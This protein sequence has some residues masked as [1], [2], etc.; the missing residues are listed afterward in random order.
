MRTV[1]IL[2]TAFW[3]SLVTANAQL[4]DQ[5][6]R[7]MFFDTAGR[8]WLA[9]DAGIYSTADG[10]RSWQDRHPLGPPDRNECSSSP[11][12]IIDAC[13]S[14]ARSAWI[15]GADL[16]V[17]QTSDSG[18]RW[19]ETT[20]S[21]DVNWK[22]GPVRLFGFGNCAIL[23]SR[24]YLFRTED[25]G[26]TWVTFE[27]GLDVR[28]DVLTQHLIQFVDCGSGIYGDSEDPPQYWST[29]DGG[30]IW[31]RVELGRQIPEADHSSSIGPIAFLNR[32]HGYLAL[33]SSQDKPATRIFMT[34]DAGKSWTP[35]PS[36]LH[37]EEQKL[38]LSRLV[39][40]PGRGVLAQ[41][42]GT[43]DFETP[44]S[45]ALLLVS[46]DTPTPRRLYASSGG[47][48]FVT[49]FATETDGWLVVNDFWEYELM[50]TDDAGQ[51]WRTLYG[52][53]VEHNRR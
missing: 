29:Q 23:V 10:G 43:A 22:T 17:W 24:E 20:P 11:Y 48:G 49:F 5:P 16:R 27:L 35:L 33:N 25:G 26:R 18:G 42:S 44:G 45:H 41:Y 13:F 7:A 37:Q 46:P 53:T 2:F 30:K 15:I 1:T 8:G 4:G 34:E 28:L 50:Y 32:T 40:R 3:A 51:S 14:D 6:V 36:D 39:P 12:R 52:A 9:G 19:Q 21:V 31:R 38:H 47:T